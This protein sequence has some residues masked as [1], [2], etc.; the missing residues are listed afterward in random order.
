MSASTTNTLFVASYVRYEEDQNVP[1]TLSFRLDGDADL[2]A[3]F[4]EAARI[5]SQDEEDAF[6][7]TGIKREDPSNSSNWTGVPVARF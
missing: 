2:V 5:L 3:A 1:G 4:F 6:L 7:V